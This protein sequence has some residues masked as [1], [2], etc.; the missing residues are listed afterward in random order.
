M[1]QLRVAPDLEIHYE[2]DDFADPWR[3]HDTIVLLHG[4]AESSVAWRA[5]VPH[6]ARTY[7]VLRPDLRGFGRSTVPPD[8]ERHRWS[9]A[10]FAE[11]IVALLDALALPAVHLAGA[12][13]GAPIAM[14][15]AADHPRRVRSLSVISGLA[16]GDDVRGLA[17]GAGVVSLASFAD[18]IHDHGLAAWFAQTGRARLGSSAEPGQVEFW[19]RLMAASDEGVCIG[20][21]QAAARLDVSGILERIQAPTLVIASRESRVQTL[22]ATRRWQRSIPGSRLVV[23]PGDSPHLAATAPDACAAEVTAFLQAVAELHSLPNVWGCPR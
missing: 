18:R 1:P 6:L 13:V 23:M 2:D 21:M 4:F 8:A 11:D 3:A 20:M 12:R 10:E 7:R 19:N 22:E 9:V 14:Q 5:W 15:I 17:T 16:R